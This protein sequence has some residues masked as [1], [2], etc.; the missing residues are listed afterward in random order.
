MFFIVLIFIS[1]KYRWRSY[2]RANKV[3]YCT[4]IIWRSR[5]HATSAS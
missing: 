3:Q 1:T 2:F 5:Y 4:G